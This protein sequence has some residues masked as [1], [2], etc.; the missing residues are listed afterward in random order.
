MNWCALEELLKE[1]IS[2]GNI[3]SV[4]QPIVDTRKQQV[5]GYEAL[6]RGPSDS[7]LYSAGVLFET[8]ERAGL[9][10][11]LEKVCRRQCASRFKALSVDGLLFVNISPGVLESPSFSHDNLEQLLNTIEIP[12]QRVV[13]ELSERYPSTDITETLSALNILKN[14][15]F[16]IAI[17]DLGAG[18][19]GLKL[20]S[21][22]QPDFVKIDRHFIRDIDSDLVK[23][24][25]VSS[26]ISL[27]NGIGCQLIAEGVETLSEYEAVHELGI[28]LCQGFYFGKPK[29]V[30]VVSNLIKLDQ[31]KEHSVSLGKVGA[32]STYVTP[33]QSNT[34]L[35]DVA[36]RF[37]QTGYVSSI[38][39]VD[40]NR[41]VG[42]ISKWSL[43]EL[44][45]LPFG[46]SLHEKKPVAQYMTH[47]PITVS[48][49][50]D[51]T[52]VSRMLTDEADLYVRQHFIIT[53]AGK[54]QGLGSTRDVLRRITDMKIRSARYANPLTLLP[55][56]VPINEKLKELENNQAPYTLAY[57]DIDNFK[58]LN[59]VLGYSIG[60]EVIQLTAKLIK[61]EV[62]HMAFIGH[63][64]GDDFLVI[65][66]GAQ[67]VIPFCQSI[68]TEFARQVQSFY[69]E[70]IKEQGY[71]KALDR[72]GER[73]HFPLSTLSVGLVQED[74]FGNATNIDISTLAAR[75]K[76]QAK[77]LTS[78]L[79]I[80]SVSSYL[81]G[82]EGEKN[83]STAAM[84]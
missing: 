25:F 23:R 46:R 30:P 27:A 20:W 12:P 29:A 57:F 53:K 71:I 55:G 22:V 16:K 60:D 82:K 47:N 45:A 58:P 38:P 17:D 5:L 14:K 11:E 34:S 18:Y 21:E 81:D 43:L 78:K 64:G 77:Q 54:Y 50:E 83:S 76:K 10:E 68:Q 67:E 61:Q 75:A 9:Q 6:S 33:V 13:L 65:F 31:K 35:G 49:D 79:S 1:V 48:F 73:Q 28:S 26:V 24:E 51:L 52:E 36:K 39:I 40:N 15:G 7:P 56:N 37:S 62:S 70:E 72:K 32:L 80:M 69:P 19:S 66:E 8:A 84:Q 41:P 74:S 42:M 2:Q 3:Q 59:D 44:F 4:F 63:I